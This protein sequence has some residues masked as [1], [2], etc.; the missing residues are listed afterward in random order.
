MAKGMTGFGRAVERDGRYEAAVEITSVNKR[1]LDV[2]VKLPRGCAQDEAAVRQTIASK[3]HRGQIT[4]AVS[5]RACASSAKA[6]FDADLLNAQVASLR[7][8]AEAI[9]AQAPVEEALLEL[10]RRQLDEDCVEIS[11]EVEGLIV[12]AVARAADE[13]DMKRA[14]EGKALVTDIKGRLKTLEALKNRI[15]ERA[16]GHVERIRQRLVDIVS[17]YV[18]TMASD[19]RVLR[20]VVLYADKADV[21][22]ELA[23]ISHHIEQMGKALAEKGPIGKMV[24]FMLQELLREFNTLGA[25]TDDAEVSTAVVVAKTE[26]EKMREQIQNV[27]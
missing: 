14:D 19:D 1:H 13:L 26:L 3:F 24:E 22:E 5:I 20:E 6:S 16:V 12:R 23:R 8:M 7:T 27:E 18:P 4:V 9:G 17:R 2:V 21:S 11:P 10:W 15:A 25:K